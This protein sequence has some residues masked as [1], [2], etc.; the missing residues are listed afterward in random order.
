MEELVSSIPFRPPPRTSSY[1]LVSRAP[2]LVRSVRREYFGLSITGTSSLVESMLKYVLLHLLIPFTHDFLLLIETYRRQVQA[3]RLG[4]LPLRHAST[5]CSYQQGQSRY[6]GIP[7]ALEA[8][9][10]SGTY[11]G[12]DINCG[13]HI[14][15]ITVMHY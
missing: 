4:W 2:F 1:S 7:R 3:V 14:Y 10:N 11:H 6:R 5:I 9:D 13:I 8:E 15:T 12:I